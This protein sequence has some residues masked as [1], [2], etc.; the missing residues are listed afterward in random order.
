MK[1]AIFGATGKTGLQLTQQALDQGHEVTALAR[2]PGKL[3]IQHDNLTVIQG[4][5][6]NQKDVDKTVLDQDAVIVSLGSSS[7]GNTGIRTNGT[8]NVMSGMKAQAVDRILV[9][10]S[11]GSGDSIGQAT[12]AA[13]FF[14][15]TLLR[16][17][18]KD[19]A[20]QEALVMKSGLTYTIVRPSALTDDARTGSYKHG[21]ASDTSLKTR[22][23]SRADV[24]DF[25]LKQIDSA[26][27]ANKAV[28]V[29]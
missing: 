29:T 18:V 4:D 7:I 15:K 14:M 8:K 28:S 12:F 19:H 26:E 5:V 2:T 10:S 21:L 17:V 13:K 9:I 20:G 11:M 24:A 3:A 6:L 23:I 1:I 25:V 16:N 27:Y 22:R